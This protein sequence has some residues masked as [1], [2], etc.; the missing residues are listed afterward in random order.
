MTREEAQALAEELVLRLARDSFTRLPK[1]LRELGAAYLGGVTQQFEQLTTGGEL[2][3][4]G[5]V[6]LGAIAIEFLRELFLYT[7]DSADN[8]RRLHTIQ[9]L[10]P[11]SPA[12]VG[13]LALESAS[14]LL[15]AGTTRGSEVRLFRLPDAPEVIRFEVQIPDEPISRK[16]LEGKNELHAVLAILCSLSVQIARAI[17]FPTFAG[18]WQAVY[19][20]HGAEILRQAEV[21]AKSRS[22]LS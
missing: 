12:D 9:D 2:R 19:D 17:G 16:S 13:T 18:R 8:I 5:V 21:R 11:A 22:T 3:T 15:H 20:A 7:G 6:M 10:S 4:N 14:R 1:G